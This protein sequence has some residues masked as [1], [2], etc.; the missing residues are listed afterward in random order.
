L[1]EVL[2]E[3]GVFKESIKAEEIKLFC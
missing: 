1:H 2:A 3:R